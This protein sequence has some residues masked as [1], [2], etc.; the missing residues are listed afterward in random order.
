MRCPTK[1]C[2]RPQAA[3]CADAAPVF[4]SVLPSFECVYFF[5]YTTFARR[6]PVESFLFAGASPRHLAFPRAKGGENVEVSDKR[7]DNRANFL[8]RFLRIFRVDSPCRLRYTE[9]RGVEHPETSQNDAQRDAFSSMQSA[10]S[11][12][13]QQMSIFVRQGMLAGRRNG[14][15]MKGKRRGFLKRRARRENA[16]A[17]GERV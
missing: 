14:D 7:Q 15:K 16:N 6:F 4:P 17:K 2:T 8:P 1:T 9:K 13:M 10:K 5:Y 11:V 3:G 12:R